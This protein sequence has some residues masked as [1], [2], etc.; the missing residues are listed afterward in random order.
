MMLSDIWNIQWFASH[1][2]ITFSTQHSIKPKQLSM[3]L[4]SF[5]WMTRE[6]I[7]SCHKYS[8]P[9]VH[10][11]MDQFY[12]PGQVGIISN[13]YCHVL[14]FNVCILWFDHAI[15]IMILFLLLYRWSSVYLITLWIILR[16]ELLKFLLIAL[17]LVLIFSVAMRFAMQAER[18]EASQLQN[19]TTNNQSE[20]CDPVTSVLENGTNT[21]CTSTAPLT[22]L[23]ASKL[24]GKLEWVQTMHINCVWIL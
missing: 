4:P 22:E 19:S 6:A 10:M 12:W 5:C 3:T 20:H 1:P 8:R 15:N 7:T 23:L 24:L 17:L 9:V 16:R 14:M 18:D 11:T 2:A 13:D 21:S